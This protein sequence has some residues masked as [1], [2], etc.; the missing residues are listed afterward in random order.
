MSDCSTH[1]FDVPL[2]RCPFCGGE[3]ELVECDY[4]DYKTGYAVYC[5]GDCR[6]KL[7]VTGRLG[8]A[9]EWTPVFDTEAEAIAAWNRRAAIEY[10]GFFYL[11]KPKESLVEYG[12]IRMFG[13]EH[14]C[15]AVQSVD[16]IENAV[17]QWGKELDERIMERIAEV[18]GASSSERTCELE[19]NTDMTAIRCSKCGYE[20]PYG[21]DL[22][23]TR[24]C[25]GCGAKAR[26]E[27]E[28]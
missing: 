5:I 19:F 23:Q 24:F 7:G 27:E 17:R 14:G 20:L 9:Y 18:F 4:G 16:I 25:G 1:A 3:A 15:K 2:M 26:T 11:P 13:T 28:E 12:Q 22:M 21:S 6:A 8:E 10:D